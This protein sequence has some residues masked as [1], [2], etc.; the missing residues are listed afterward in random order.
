MG[1]EKADWGRRLTV[2][3]KAWGVVEL[4]KGSRGGAGVRRGTLRRGLADRR[5]PRALA[6]MGRGKVILMTGGYDHTIRW[7]RHPDSRAP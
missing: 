6:R 1:R 5:K 7:A 2:E 4:A 3:K